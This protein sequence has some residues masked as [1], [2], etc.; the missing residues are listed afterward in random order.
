MAVNKTKTKLLNFEVHLEMCD[1]KLISEDVKRGDRDYFS[2]RGKH[3]DSEILFGDLSL[4]L[5]VSHNLLYIL[6][7]C[8]L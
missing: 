3:R 6:G 8:F 5:G 1:Y 4:A 2:H 7:V